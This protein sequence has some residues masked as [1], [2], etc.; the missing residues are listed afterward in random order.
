[1]KN[2][3]SHNAPL[4]SILVRSVG[5]PELVVALDSIASQTYP[6][7]EVIVVDALGHK[8][9][10]LG[11]YCRSFPI[12]LYSTGKPLRRSTA[13]NLGLAHASGKFII[14]LDDDDY[15]APEH[16]S[17]LAKILLQYPDAHAAYTGVEVVDKT[18]TMVT[19]I[20]NEPYHQL[21]LLQKNYIPIHAVLFDRSLIDAGCRFDLEM[22]I[23]E[24]WDFW[25][26][27]SMHTRFIHINTISAYYRST[28]NSSGAGAGSNVD[29]PLK[30]VGRQKIFDKWKHTQ[31]NLAEAIRSKIQHGIEFQRGGRLEKA[32]YLYEEVL[33]IQPDNLNALHLLG[34]IEYNKQ[35]YNIAI[36]LIKRA[37]QIN[38][39]VA[40]LHLNLGL[41]LQALGKKQEAAESY[42]RALAIDTQNLDAQTMLNKLIQNSDRTLKSGSSD[43]PS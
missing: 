25:I 7:I 30:M 8:H 21:L 23:Y 17:I 11:V 34:M 29:E 16:I 18:G 14:F 24:D 32:Q 37:L 26:Q 13:A 3:I 42:Q 22:D 41:V 39:R 2:N 33:S 5:R 43:L 40:G 4:A 31:I 6:N 20:I 12:R 9:P 27:V 28:T 35:R 36:K 19:G 1:M 38:D 15:F 10:N